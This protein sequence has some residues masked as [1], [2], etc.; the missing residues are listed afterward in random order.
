MSFAVDLSDEVIETIAGWRPRLG[1]YPA[2]RAVPGVI[3]E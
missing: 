1:L 2:F 3:D